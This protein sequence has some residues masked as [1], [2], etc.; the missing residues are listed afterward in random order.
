MEVCQC[1]WQCLCLDGGSSVAWLSSPSASPLSSICSISLL[2]WWISLLVVTCIC[3]TFQMYLS[4]LPNVFV[5]FSKCI[6]PNCQ[7]YLSR[8]PNVFVRITK[9]IC[10]NCQMYLS[11]CPNVFVQIAKI[12]LSKSPNLFVKIVKCICPNCKCPVLLG[13]AAR[14]QV[15]SHQSVPQQFLNFLMEFSI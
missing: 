4:K 5:Q 15:H 9:C 8:L 3:P 2:F 1:D 12:Y 7:M 13:W 14:L 6:C 11:N 10:P